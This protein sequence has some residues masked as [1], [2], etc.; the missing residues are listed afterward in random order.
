M[1]VA[2]V[3]NTGHGRL[4]SGTAIVSSVLV[5]CVVAIGALTLGRGAAPQGASATQGVG[6]LLKRLAVLRRPQ[7]AADRSYPYLAP[8]LQGRA[9]VITRNLTR[10]AATTS[11]A[12]GPVRVYVIV[13]KFPARPRF[14]RA[15]LLTVNAFAVD[16]HNQL[17]G[18]TGPLTAAMIGTPGNAGSRLIPSKLGISSSTGVTV[19][20]VPDGVVR[21]K[22]VFS[23]AGFGITH[24]REVTV[25]PLVRQNVAVAAITSGQGPLAHATWYGARGQ[26]LASGTGNTQE[27]LLLRAIRSVNASRRRAI[28]PFLLAHFGLFRSVPADTPARIRPGR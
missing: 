13:R 25:Y 4:A 17:A 27:Q 22:W 8:G 14:G 20:I 21:V 11:S 12:T 6:G 1:R 26:V 15:G 2:D 10:L 18:A 3:G 16:A 23:G 7:T 28:A 9:G 5:V 19:G 24:A